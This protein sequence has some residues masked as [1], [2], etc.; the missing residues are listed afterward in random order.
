M[1]NKRLILFT[2]VLHLLSYKSIEGMQ[3]QDIGQYMAIFTE[4]N[5]RLSSLPRDVMHACIL[6]CLLGGIQYT[7]GETPLHLAASLGNEPCLAA[8]LEA[9]TEVDI[10]DDEGLTPLHYASRSGQ[11]AMVKRLILVGADIHKRSGQCG[12]V[13][14]RI[15]ESDSTN[16]TAM[17]FAAAAGRKAVIE[18]LVANGAAIDLADGSGSTP[19]LLAASNGHVRVI[20]CLLDLGANI[21]QKDSFAMTALHRAAQQGQDNV[22]ELLIRRG[23]SCVS[24]RDDLGNTPLLHAVRDGHLR[25]LRCLV[26]HGADIEEENNSKCRAVHYAAEQGPVEVLKFLL[27]RRANVNCSASNGDTP[28][29]CAVRGGS[30]SAVQLLLQNGAQVDSW[31]KL[32][33]QAVGGSGVNELIELVLKKGTDINGIITNE[34]TGDFETALSVAVRCGSAKVVRFLLSRG[35][36]FLHP[37]FTLGTPQFA[38]LFLLEVV[39]S[40]SPSSVIFAEM[41]RM[42]MNDYLVKKEYT[43]CLDHFNHGGRLPIPEAVR[44]AGEAYLKNREFYVSRGRLQEGDNPDSVFAVAAYLLDVQVLKRL[45]DQWAGQLRSW[46]DSAGQNLL[47]G[48]LEI[49]DLEALKW[50]LDEKI[51]AIDDVD[52]EGHDLLWHAIR[53]GD[54]LIID[55]ILSAGAQVTPEHIIYASGHQRYYAA[56]FKNFE[57]AAKLVL[58]YRYSAWPKEQRPAALN[59]FGRSSKRE[60]R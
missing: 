2:V 48:A 15:L 27:E 1:V 19:F 23:L 14:R 55:D 51:C 16:R 22:L 9:G 3:K 31:Q 11:C 12:M 30:L 54:M 57:L 5:S 13:K 28:V 4:A 43:D 56:S 24:G 21:W 29:L 26:L 47:M 8:A 49:Y 41:V 36:S 46:R 34:T 50:L 7:N 44:V 42:I 32:M 33:G 20:E 53:L 17:H 40:S 60:N 52:S 6:P 45:K 25:T 59:L 58:L 38:R 10:T 37:S 18:I 39:G 35:A